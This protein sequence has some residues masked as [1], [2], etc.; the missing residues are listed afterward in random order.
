MSLVTLAGL[1]GLGFL[2]GL[3][4][5][6]ALWWTTRRLIG[7]GGAI[8]LLACHLGRFALLFG[9]LVWAAGLGAWP[10]LA[11]A[12]GIIFARVATVRQLGSTSA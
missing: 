6:G 4:F 1:V 5:F 12:A 9:A 2:V 7:G 11:M 10:L 3:L 8:R